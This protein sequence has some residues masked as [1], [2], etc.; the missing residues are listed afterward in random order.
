MDPGILEGRNEFL[1]RRC[2]E[3]EVG[4]RFGI[5]DEKVGSVIYMKSCNEGIQ[6]WSAR[7]DVHHAVQSAPVQTSQRAQRT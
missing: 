7:T 2:F 5:F 1:S 6:S 3:G 4:G